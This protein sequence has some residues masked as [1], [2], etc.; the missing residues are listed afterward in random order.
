MDMNESSLSFHSKRSFVSLFATCLVLAGTSFS[1]PVHAADDPCVSLNKLMMDRVQVIQRI[2]AFKDKKPTAEEAC[3]DFTQ[4][5]KVNSTSIKSLERDGAWCRAPDGLADN[6][7]AQQ[8]QIEMG[9][10]NACKAAAEQKKAAANGG[11]AQRAPLGGTGDIL[12]GP[13]K[14]PQGAL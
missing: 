12:G 11:A 3:G 6:F 4:L 10:T 2:Q 5:A 7:K 14:L 13:M 9:K 1:L 8:V